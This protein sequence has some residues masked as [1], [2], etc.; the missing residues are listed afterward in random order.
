MSSFRQIERSISRFIPFYRIY[1]LVMYR[2]FVKEHSYESNQDLSP[3]NV[4]TTT[5]VRYTTPGR[6]ALATVFGLITA[7]PVKLPRQRH[8]SQ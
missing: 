8:L 1:F 5:S 3:D 7:D 2:K 4:Y 6:N